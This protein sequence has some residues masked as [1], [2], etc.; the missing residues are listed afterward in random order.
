M[1]ILLLGNCQVSVLRNFCSYYLNV[2]CDYL[3]VVNDLQ[4]EKKSTTDL[5]SNCDLCISQHFYSGKYYYD[6]DKI[7]E[8]INNREKI[9]YIHVLY[10]DGY[11]IDNE[12][13]YSQLTTKINN[14][15][16]LKT[17][18]LF[19]LINEGFSN[20]EIVKKLYEDFSDE[21]IINNSNLSLQKLYE[22]ENGL[23]N[24]RPV[25]IKIYDYIKENYKK[26]KLF[27]TLN[28]PC[29]LLLN[30]YSIKICKYIKNDDLKPY[31]DKFDKD[32]EKL[33]STTIP[34]YKKVYEALNLE[35]ENYIY[36]KYK[37]YDLISYIEFLKCYIIKDG[38]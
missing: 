2:N 37:K 16:I 1:K 5:I 38:Y 36:H 33:G 3:N 15:N 14:L 7:L 17:P 23:K 30:H 25:D 13:K 28:H 8:L 9:I 22:R 31:N 32:Y 27:H 24:N 21:E 35:F 6:D 19:H 10:Y 11:F 4:I 29:N 34:I 26:I 18:Y 20:E 12:K